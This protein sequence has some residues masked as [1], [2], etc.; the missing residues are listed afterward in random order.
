MDGALGILIKLGVRLVV[1]GLTFFVAARLNPKVLIHNKWA[2]PLIALV[3]ATLNTALYWILKPVLNIATL[4]ALGF[5][6]PFIANTLFLYATLKIFEKKKWIEIQGML[7]TL[8][9]AGVLTIT[10]GALWFALDYLPSKL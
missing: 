6:M 4:G 3:F 2:T 1:F 10:H 8:W 7:T 9:M 5:I